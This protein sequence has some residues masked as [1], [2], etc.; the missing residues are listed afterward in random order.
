MNKKTSAIILALLLLGVFFLPF[1]SF[2]QDYKLSGF[3]VVFGKD[4]REGIGQGRFMF[5]SLLIPLGA[6]LIT[7]SA[8]TERSSTLSNYVYWM[9][10]LGLIY[11]TIMSFLEMQSGARQVGGSLSFGQMMGTLA[12]GYWLTLAASVLVVATRQTR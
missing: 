9:P 5:V 10:L 12:Y 6:V 4:G 8:L 2:T 3:E 7:L 11:L 1:L